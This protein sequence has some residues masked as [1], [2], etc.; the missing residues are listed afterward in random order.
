MEQIENQLLKELNEKRFIE[1]SGH[2][3][4]S[5]TICKKLEKE[6][7]IIVTWNQEDKPIL[8]AQSSN[9]RKKYDLMF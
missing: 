1:Y 8:I 4:Y 9:F 7:W 2:E 6:G 5:T 3:F